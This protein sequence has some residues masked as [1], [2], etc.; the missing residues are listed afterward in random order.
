MHRQNRPCDNA[1][2]TGAKVHSLAPTMHLLMQNRHMLSSP[3]F[4]RRAVCHKYTAPL[5]IPNLLTP[6]VPGFPVELCAQLSL[7]VGRNSNSV[8]WSALFTHARACYDARPLDPQHNSPTSIIL[9]LRKPS[10]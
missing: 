1:H 3:T 10:R 6:E 4:F 9:A 2:R 8:A 5:S 7:A